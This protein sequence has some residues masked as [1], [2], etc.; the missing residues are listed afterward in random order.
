MLQNNPLFLAL[1]FST[2]NEAMHFLQEHELYSVPVKIG[3]ELYYQEGPSIIHRLKET[4]HPIF[5]DLKLH[6]I[7]NT[8]K[9]AMRVIASLGVDVVN[10]H[11]AGGTSMI[12]AAQEGLVEGTPE[13]HGK[14]KLIAV[15]QLTSTSPAM[16]KEELMISKSME[17][18]VGHYA[19]V[20]RDGGADGVVCSVHEADWIHTLCG[21]DFMTVTPG[22]RLKGS[23]IDDQVRIATPGEAGK[24]GSDAIV[25]GRSITKAESPKAAYF[26]ALKEWEN[27]KRTNRS[28]SLI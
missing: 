10:V 14:P 4:G 18:T 3:M 23:A 19:T 25:I 24:R 2:G 27:E 16:L 1:D 7:P 11:A 17:E 12:R 8:V 13:G 15:T 21:P 28:R 5:L 9:K 26:A 6:D 20:S 22:I